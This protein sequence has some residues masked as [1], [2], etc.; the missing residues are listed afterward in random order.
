MGFTNESG[1]NGGSKF[2]NFSKGM[3]TTKVDGE[4]KSFTHLEGDIIDIS[5]EDAEYQGEAY[6]KIVLYISHEDGLTQLGFPFNSGYGN[7]FCRLCPNID[8]S[9]R[10]KI[11]GGTEPD[12]NDKTKSYSKLFV[13]QSGAYVKW[14]FKKDTDN[15]KLV[16]DVK[17]EK[18]GKGKSAKEVKDYSDRDE[19]FERVIV[20][21]LEKVQVMYPKGAEGYH[22]K[23]GHQDAT[24]IT[25]PIDD[26][27]F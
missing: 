15:G 25:E 3:I 27:P 19:F 20:R 11:S 12:P 5:I 13:Q 21:F 24:D 16:P 6:R 4:K 23:G 22:S 9:K 10:V 14:F 17:I 2:A 26:L 18:I 8:P 1:S 7:A